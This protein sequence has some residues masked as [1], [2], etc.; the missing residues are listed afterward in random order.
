[1]LLNPYIAGNPVG[2]STAFVG[3]SDVLRSVLRV[4]K[5]PSD[6]ALVLFGQRRIGKTSVL[7]ELVQRLPQAGPYQPLFFDLQDK[8]ARPLAA[9]LR[10]LADRLAQHVGL[11]P[12]SVPDADLPQH[13]RAAF[14]PEVLRRL[15]E[16]SSL[17]LLFDE[18]D[19]LDNPE[20][21]QAGAAFFPYLRDLLTLSPRLQFIFV[22]GRRPEDLSSL[23]LSVFKGVKAERV[24][25]LAPEDSAE[26]V[27]LAEGNGS[28]RWSDAALAQVYALTGGHPFLAQQLCQELWESAYEGN[29]AQPPT[30]EPAAVDGA[31]TATL[32]SASNA[33]EWLWNGLSP[34]QRV[35]AAALASAGPQAISQE[36]LERRLQASGVR[37]LVGELQ[38][39]PQVLQEWDLISAG[40]DGYRFR[41]ELLRR[42]I[43]ER[44]PLARVQ[45]EIDFI[46]PAAENLFRAAY[47]FYQ[48][49]QLE[50]ALPLLRQTVTLNPNHVRGSLLLAEILLAQGQVDEARQL[51]ETLAQVHPTAARP[52]LVQAMLAQAQAVEEH[53][54]RLALYE[55]ILQWEPDQPTA[56]GGR[57]AI[58]RQQVTGLEQAER[59]G[60]ALALARRLHAE[61]PLQGDLL[62][63]LAL[64]ERKTQ[65][66]ELYQRGLEALRTSDRATATRLLVEVVGLEPGYRAVTRYLHL[67]VSGVDA[68]R[69]STELGQERTSRCV[70]A[71]FNRRATLM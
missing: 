17:V 38:N 54:E 34:A 66:A 59:Y 1:M 65:L 25:L 16:D 14:V 37:I 50:Q 46:Q 63:D 60:E 11:T 32:R 24:S 4:L 48:N 12:P 56:R 35:V 9:V 41:V 33:L 58:W 19:V 40:A 62:P 10:E 29:P 47:A 43:V 45:E 13:F 20:A 23:T 53:D 61:A 67:A 36:E 28:L 52:R 27:R 5:S 8:A 71:R 68:E 64:L 55:Q 2:G 31:V 51:L 49:G 18:F 15:P 21:N 6:N 42:W 57:Q 30:V 3:R 26:L 22:I 7:Q 39:A 69:L 70:R 44:K